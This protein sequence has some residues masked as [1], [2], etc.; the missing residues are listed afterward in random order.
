MSKKKNKLDFSALEIILYI[1]N[2]RSFFLI[3]SGLAFIVSSIVSYTITPKFKSA[4]VMFPTAAASV[5]ATLMT[6]SA[7]SSN[8]LLKFG[9]EQESEQLMQVLQCGDIRSHIINR[10]NLGS[11]Y[12]IDPNSKT[13]YFQLNSAYDQN[14]KFRRTEFM[15]IVIEVMDENPKIAADIANDISGYVDTV[16]NQITHER[17]VKAFY[18]VEKEYKELQINI[19]NLQDSLYRIRN[20]KTYYTSTNEIL[21]KYNE[22][23]AVLSAK[24]QQTRVDV[25]QNL[26]CKYIVE[27]AYLSDKKATPIR[28][29]IVFVTVVST[30]FVALFLLLIRESFKRIQ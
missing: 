29:I 22:Q 1:W 5:S 19:K 28:W 16:M 17:A 27:K 9:G 14:I 20:N 18:L 8:E 26:P 7:F 15:S 12:H 4:V 23:L 10:Y 25:E 2:K 21:P 13:Y 6:Q 24:L 30:F 11:H 3:I